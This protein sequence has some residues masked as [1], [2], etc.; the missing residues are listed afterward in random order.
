MISNLKEIKK[1][2]KNGIQE[3]IG[4]SVAKMANLTPTHA[5]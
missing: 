5:I 4:Q 3:N 2:L 1:I